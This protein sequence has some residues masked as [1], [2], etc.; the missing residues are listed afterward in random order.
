MSITKINGKLF[1]LNLTKSV[2]VQLT[3][4]CKCCMIL[5]SVLLAEES[6]GVLHRTDIPK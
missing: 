4:N 2:W 3:D 1:P 5:R 6:N